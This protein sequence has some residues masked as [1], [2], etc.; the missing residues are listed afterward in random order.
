MLDVLRPG[1]LDGLAVCCAGGARAAR[2]RLEAL[3]ARVV[4]LGADLGDED[5]V[6]AEV[7][8]LGRIDVLVVDAATPF[9]G[10]GMPAL[11]A[12]V[13]GSWNAVRA[14]VNAGWTAEG[15]GAGGGGKVILVAPAPDAGEHATAVGAALENAARTLSIEWSRFG[16]RT[17]AIVP[18]AGAGAE[19]V[20]ELVAF[21]ASPAGD[22]FSGCS[23]APGGV[24]GALH[25][26]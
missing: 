9:G 3:G 24:A 15:A 18:R 14:V 21:L 13:D 6:A 23:F 4:A 11:R 17:V 19:E 8:G 7:A 2:G 1:V 12:A 10:G 25:L 26:R 5:A 20:D 22:Y 16:V